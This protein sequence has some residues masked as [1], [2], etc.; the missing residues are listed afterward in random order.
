MLQSEFGSP[1]SYLGF[2]SPLDAPFLPAGMENIDFALPLR[3]VFDSNFFRCK[4]YPYSSLFSLS[5]A[6]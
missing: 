3:E 2:R 6:I 1:F 5:L 4:E